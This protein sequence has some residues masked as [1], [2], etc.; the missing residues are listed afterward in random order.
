MNS[1]APSIPPQ[2]QRSL[3]LT[4]EERKKTSCRFGMIRGAACA[5]GN[6][7]YFNPGSTSSVYFYDYE[8]KRQGELPQCPTSQFALIVI[9]GQLMTVGGTNSN[10]LFG[11]SKAQWKET[12]PPMSINREYPAAVCIGHY[13]VVAGGH[14]GH[15]VLAS[16]EVMDTNTRQW[17]TAASLPRGVYRASMTAHGDMLYLLGDKTSEV[18]Y[19]SS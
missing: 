5:V 12:F 16:V 18:H 6:V 4:W 2:K 14:N 19:C 10:K 3:V 11:F 17:C 13:V 1:A 8:T 9:N 7:A 15:E